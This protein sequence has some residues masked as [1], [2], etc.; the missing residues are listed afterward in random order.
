MIINF[1]ERSMQV[2]PK[3]ETRHHRG[4]RYIL[5][6]DPHAPSDHR[7]V[8]RATVTRAY[9]FIGNGSTIETAARAA[10]KRIDFALRIGG[11]G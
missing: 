7:W 4:Q 5:E 2:K 10:R 1:H 8:W 11:D 9:E 3:T 6:F